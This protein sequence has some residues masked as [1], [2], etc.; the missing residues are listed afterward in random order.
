[1]GSR[2][3]FPGSFDPLTVAH[4]AIADAARDELG[5]TRLD[6]AI[7]RVALDKE[8]RTTPV[9]DRID[10]IR[11]LRAGRPWLDAVVTDAQLLA[12][13]AQGY[14]VLVIGADKW[15]Q[16]LDVRFYGGSPRARDE[17]LAR[18]PRLAVA[19]RAGADLPAGDGVHVLR[20]PERHQHVSSTAVRDGRHDWRA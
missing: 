1:M 9:Q 7:S 18:L 17:A 16:L 12:D 19:P 8:D 13:V 4:V 5:V 15:H 6:F 3:V 10:A 2:A 11:S 20:L 14:D